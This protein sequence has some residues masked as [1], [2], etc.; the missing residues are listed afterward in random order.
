MFH[1]NSPNNS[2][3]T[4]ATFVPDTSAADF[5]DAVKKLAKG[6]LHPFHLRLDTIFYISPLFL[7]SLPLMLCSSLIPLAHFCTA[8]LAMGLV[9]VALNQFYAHFLSPTHCFFLYLN[10]SRKS[11]GFTFN[12][13]YFPSLFKNADSNCMTIETLLL[14][15]LKTPSSMDLVPSLTKTL[16]SK[17]SYNDPALHFYILLEFG[18]IARSLY[19][20]VSLVARPSSSRVKGL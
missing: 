14:C 3:S 6:D 11:H 5:L 10:L 9:T 19:F 18:M 4:T 12:N 15:D 16:L 17:N 20:L 8:I 7:L 2:Y 1:I 13:N